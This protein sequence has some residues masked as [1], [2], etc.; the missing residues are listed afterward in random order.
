MSDEEATHR[1]RKLLGTSGF[2]FQL[3]VEQ[4]IRDTSKTH[5][6]TIATRE[7]PWRRSN[8]DC[9]F[10]DLVL[11]NETWDAVYLVIEAKLQRSQTWL[12]L[13][14]QRERDAQTRIRSR[15]TYQSMSE[16]ALW[17]WDEWS[18]E[19][20]SHECEFAVVDK[21]HG[22]QDGGQQSLEAIARELLSGVDALAEEELKLAATFPWPNQHWVHIPMIVTAGQ[23]WVTKFDPREVSLEDGVPR[24]AEFTKVPMVRFRRTLATEI[25]PLAQARHAEEARA[26]QERT[27]LIVDVRHLVTVL[28]QWQF[29]NREPP[30]VR[31]KRIG[32]QHP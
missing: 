26:D 27:V 24:N 30:W 1:L 4:L 12:F 9:G 2:P 15:W 7:H 28:T 5:G 22:Q 19:P 3:A 14:P 20:A 29:R 8:G 11:E 10:L 31:I 32:G 25:A 17:G 13:Q 23:L 21:N 16:P 6:W 18:T